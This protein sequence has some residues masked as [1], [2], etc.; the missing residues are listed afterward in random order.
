MDKQLI[1]S[2]L[3]LSIAIVIG[4]I[5]LYLTHFVI[6]KIYKS[7]YPTDNPY[8]NTAFLIFM[9][10]M[11]FSIA[12]LLSGIIH[13]LSSTL[14]ILTKSYPDTTDLILSYSKYLGLFVLIGLVLGGVI[15]FLAYFLFSSLTTQVNELDE[16]KQGNIG[17]AVFISVMAIMMA[18]FCKEPFLVVLESFIPYPEMPRLF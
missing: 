6:V 17:I 5:A 7:K 13:P 12:Y 16:I 15:N 9:S 11:M 3:E 2:F 18:V 4:L 14:D 8:K 10:G 1:I